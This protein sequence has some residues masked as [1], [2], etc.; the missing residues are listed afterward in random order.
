MQVPWHAT[1]Q[2][3]GKGRNTSPFLLFSRKE[4]KVQADRG[5]KADHPASAE[6]VCANQGV[7]VTI[8]AVERILH[9]LQ[10]GPL[11]LEG[12]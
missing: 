11:T 9:G 2:V 5:G 3:L 6:G 7:E 4:V 1:R 8:G 12:I 10:R